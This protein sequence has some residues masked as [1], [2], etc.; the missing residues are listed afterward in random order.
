MLRQEK[1]TVAPSNG[2]QTQAAMSLSTDNKTANAALFAPL[3]NP[4]NYVKAYKKIR[5]IAGWKES[6][7]HFQLNFFR[8]VSKII[9]EL[10]QGT[11]RPSPFR[12]FTV[13]ERG[14]KR[15]IKALSIR[16][17]LI[18]H[19]LCDDVLLPV[20][21]PYLIHDNG[22]SLKG[23]GIS[24]TRRR[25]VQHL[26]SYIRH[27]GTDGYILQIDFRKFF[28]NIPHAQLLE[29]FKKHIHDPKLTALLAVLIDSN[30]TDI[31]DSAEDLEHGI[32]DS[33]KWHSIP[34][35][36]TGAKFLHKGLGIGA[37][38][39]QISGIYYP[40]PIDTYIKTVKGVKYYGRYM[41]DL[42]IIHSSK[43]YLR[44]LL[45][46]IKQI[47]A[48]L[49][50]HIH[51]NKTHI[52]KLSR[53]FVFLKIKYRITQTGRIIQT[54]HRSTLARER[55]R[56]NALIR[57]CKQGNISLAKLAALFSSWL[58]AFLHYRHSR[59]SLQTIECRYLSG[60]YDCVSAK[61][62]A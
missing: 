32:F 25:F 45:Y 18:Q 43:D 60:F 1:V 5:T 49:N 9:H 54:L 12:R 58:C 26:S 20:L 38:L 14:H 55:R 15:L 30:K 6:V 29:S 61:R 57:F 56:L 53:P 28:D 48:P 31:S 35:Q 17:S 52:I 21:R 8:N 41:D 16:D 10:E 39:S 36:E 50:I 34:H 19:V 3:L 4:D 44:Q 59:R 46:E 24:F 23:K 33:L 13:C 62:C 47:A 22:A 7:Q 11:Y 40:S 2:A 51:E 42:Y 37:P 27:H